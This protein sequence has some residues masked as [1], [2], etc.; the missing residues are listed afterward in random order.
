MKR[1]SDIAGT[2]EHSIQ[3]A[4]MQWIAVAGM[5]GF[6]TAWKFDKAGLLP[7]PPADPAIPELKWLFAI[8][9]GGK[10]GDGKIQARRGAEMKAE[11]VKAGVPDLMWPIPRGG[12]HG[13]W[14]E[15]KTPTGRIRKEQTEFLAFAALHGYRTDVCRSWHEAARIIETYYNS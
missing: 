4:L 8:P 1:P 15:M 13:L 3:A 2:S 11:G 7:S 12:Y 14:I 10:R 5:H 9:N 6:Q